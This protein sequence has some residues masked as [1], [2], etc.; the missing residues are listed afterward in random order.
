MLHAYEREREA[1]SMPIERYD[2]VA[3]LIPALKTAEVAFYD[4]K[5]D[6]LI[7]QVHSC[8]QG[9]MSLFLQH[10]AVSKTRHRLSC[11]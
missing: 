6:C 9:I 3:M 2:E 1:P 10:F 7:Q 4:A 5:G 11:P 8:S